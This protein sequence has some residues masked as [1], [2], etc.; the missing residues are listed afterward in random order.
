[1]TVELVVISGKGGTGKTSIA[2]SLAVLAAP[3][4]VADCDVDA[5]DLHLVLRP[6]PVVTH[7][8]FSGREAFVEQEK[9][10]RCGLCADLC[11]FSSF[12]RH[13]DEKGLWRV[14]VRPLACEGCGV[15]VHYCGAGAIAF[16]EKLRGRWYEATTRWGPMVHAALDPGTGNSGKLVTQVRRRASELARERKAAW[17][18]TDGSPGIGCPV[19]ASLTGATHVLAVTEPSVS[20]VHDLARLLEL[21]RHF[22]IPTFV[23]VNKSDICESAAG[24]IERTC[25]DGGARFAGRIPYAP[26]FGEAQAA[27]RAVVEGDGPGARAIRALWEFIQRAVSSDPAKEGKHDESD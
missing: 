25:L 13:Q 8:F 21:T 2:A 23:C 22:S 12:D 19:I 1:M 16:P 11:A 20:G 17:V 10:L 15:C 5:A 26:E 14:R 18:I 9:C 27:G 4:V 7:D 6:S 3:C 24:E